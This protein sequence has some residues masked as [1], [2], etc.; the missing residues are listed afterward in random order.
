MARIALR[1]LGTASVII[2]C[3]SISLGSEDAKKEFKSFALTVAPKEATAFEHKDSGFFSK[4]YSPDFKTKDEHGV[5]NGKKVAIFLLRYHFNSLQKLN[6]HVKILSLEASGK[7]GTVKMMTVL[8]GVTQG[9]GGAKGTAIKVTRVEKQVFVKQ[10]NEWL[11]SLDE[12][13]QKPLVLMTGA[14]PFAP[15]KL[16]PARK[17]QH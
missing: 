4:L 16:A 17:P 7:V 10:G 1:A 11:M 14:Q 8:N 6:Y 9:R 5:T 12:D 2:S 15:M 13:V 3:A